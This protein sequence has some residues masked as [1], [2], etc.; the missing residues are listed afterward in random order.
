MIAVALNDDGRSSVQFA[1]HPLT[2]DA[3][4]S[5]YDEYD[6]ERNAEIRHWRFVWPSGVEVAFTGMTDRRGQWESGPDSADGVARY[7][8]GVLGWPVPSAG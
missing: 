1:R 6:N 4:I 3:S 8:A 7:I 5:G 2:G